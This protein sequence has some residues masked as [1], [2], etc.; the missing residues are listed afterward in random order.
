MG[1]INQTLA[2]DFFSFSY[3]LMKENI[4]PHLGPPLKGEENIG[5]DRFPF[6]W[7]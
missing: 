3:S 1:S 6:S 7:E 4:H 5:K 2:L